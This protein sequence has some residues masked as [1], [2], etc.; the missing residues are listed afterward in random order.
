MIK[1]PRYVALSLLLV[2]C[3]KAAAQDAAADS[4]NT[5]DEMLVEGLP[6]DET[7]LPTVRPVSS[8]LGTDANVLNTPRSVSTITKAQL[9]A[10]QIDDVNTLGQYSSGTYTPSIF[11]AQG[12]PT[13]RGT[14][15]E[16]Y[17]NGQRLKFYRN[18]LPPSFNSVEALDIVKGPG[19]PVF[20]PA[21]IGVGGYVNFV[22]KQ[23]Y[24]DKIHLTVDLKLGTYVP[25]GQSY[26][27]PD[28]TVDL[29]VP[30]IKDKL[31]VRL[32]YQ[33]READGYYRNTVDDLQDVF[34]AVTFIANDKLT[35]DYTAQFYETRFNENVGWNRVTQELIDSGTYVSGPITPL[36]FG[37]TGVPWAGYVGPGTDGSFEDQKVH[38]YP[39]QTLTGSGDSAYGKRF[40]TQLTTTYAINDDWKVVNRML[41]DDVESR[42]FSTYG[43]SEYSPTN[44]AFDTR[45]ELQ[46]S[47]GLFGS[48][49]S[50]SHSDGKKVVLE[51]EKTPGI[52]NNIIT[53]MS[54]RWENNESYQDFNNEPFA[55]YDLYNGQQPQFP[56]SVVMGGGTIPGSGGYTAGTFAGQATKSNY[57]DL[58]LFFQDEIKIT[59]WLSLI[60]GVR[61]DFIEAEARQPE[62]GPSLDGGISYPG[63]PEGPE[64]RKSATNPAY[65]GSLMIKPKEWLT[66]YATYNKVSSIQGNNNFG[67]LPPDLTKNQLQNESELYETG[68]KVSLFDNTLYASVAG[69]YQTRVS[70]NQLNEASAVQSRGI[71]IEAT[72][73]PN[74]NFNASMN[75]TFVNS[76]YSGESFIYSQ[77]GNY[78]D[79]IGP[80]FTDSNGGK[81]KGGVDPFSG[82]SP[83]YA[84]Y[85]TPSKSPD[86]PGQPDFLFNAYATYMFDFGLGFSV[87]PQVTGEIKQNAQGTLKIP[88]QVTW[89]AAVF[90]KQPA[91]EVQL[92]VFNFTDERNYTP[93]AEFAS[94]DLVFPNE[95]LNADITF[96]FRF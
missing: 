44:Q 32:S 28:W 14:L 68:V 29:S 91:W 7:V 23:P 69:Y 38:L 65:F 30:I 48:S 54:F 5:L 35:F 73:Q 66:L 16:L 31:A 84:G 95:P 63:N 21:N 74:R 37:G 26:F 24:F 53:G 27:S 88:A 1:L 79:T 47:F 52:I 12:V 82:F 59:D 45:L 50:V 46:G 2:C 83:N 42:K 55:V 77:T 78:L 92:N 62:L 8:V 22:T 70:R 13:I 34:A 43:Y 6:A 61:V 3:N 51:E 19:S 56:K 90:Y 80:E 72:Y 9:E 93:T 17:Q 41:Y 76:N 49:T 87:G 40:T 20:G 15:A 67:S 58:G 11:G 36:F 64:N 25:G 96:K 81:G 86:L 18:S 94:N 57:W 60:G 71:E 89:N 75:M 39:F 85:N 4:T 33:G 10:R